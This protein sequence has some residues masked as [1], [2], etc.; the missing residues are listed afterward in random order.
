MIRFACPQ[1]TTTLEIDDGFAGQEVKCG[2]CAAAAIA[3][4]RTWLAPMSEIPKS[5]LA[6]SPAHEHAAPVPDWVSEAFQEGPPARPV[7][8]QAELLAVVRSPRSAERRMAGQPLFGPLKTFVVVGLVLGAGAAL[9]ALAF[10]FSERTNPRTARKAAANV[11]LGLDNGKI[12]SSK[13]HRRPR[14]ESGAGGT[15]AQTQLVSREQLQRVLD[16]QAVEEKEREERAWLREV[17]EEIADAIES[18]KRRINDVNMRL[19][20]MTR[21]QLNRSE[22]ALRLIVKQGSV[23]G[24]P[25]HMVEL[26]ARIDPGI[27]KW[28]Q[29]DLL[30][31]SG[32]AP[33]LAKRKQLFLELEGIV[34]KGEVRWY[35]FGVGTNE[36]IAQLVRDLRAGP[37]RDLTRRQR[38]ILLEAGAVEYVGE[39]VRALS[40]GG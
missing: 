23:K 13:K 3:P 11:P 6:H 29:D 21:S 40:A 9:G 27:V 16:R 38:L 12:A 37:F 26:A 20:G 8:H 28:L 22:A 35:L 4:A 19:G 39:K 17:N 33:E 5:Q 36:D 1:C 2:V 15:T 18:R 10:F 25:P 7:R 32:A 30:I 34:G 24:A 31:Q 14:S